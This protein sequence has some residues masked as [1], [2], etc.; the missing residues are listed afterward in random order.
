MKPKISYVT[1]T[2]RDN[3]P[4]VG[5]KNLHLWQPTLDTLAKQTFQEFEYIIVDVY[6]EERKEYF[7][8]HNQKL[9]IKH[10][11]AAPNVWYDKGVVQTCHQFNKGIIH[12]DGDLLFFDADSSMLPPDLMANL[13]QHYQ[14]GWFVSLGFGADLTFAPEISEYGNQPVAIAPIKTDWY[15]FGYRGLVT[16]DHRFIKLFKEQNLV[17]APIPPDWYYGISTVSLE[18]ALKV[19]GFNLALD[20][21][22]GLNDIEFGNRLAIAGYKNLAM[23]RDSYVIEAYAGVNW[24]P[25]MRTPRPEIKCNYALLLYN[26]L[27]AKFRANEGMVDPDD[28]IKRIC[29]GTCDLQQ[30]CREKCSHRAPFYNKN[31]K[32]LY[33]YWLKWGANE[34][35][36]LAIEREMRKS[37]DDHTEGTFINCGDE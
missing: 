37:G 13:W 5:L 2:A 3:F 21:D 28:V 14:R 20:G 24:H 27:I 25:K 22:P 30:T 9:R 7:K 4:T 11:P 31:E 29:K 34:Q 18:A 36:D 32:D 23:F 6:Y 17:F 1:I 12:A 35:Q 33:E 16:M 15:N 10:V 8:E 26:R 19:N